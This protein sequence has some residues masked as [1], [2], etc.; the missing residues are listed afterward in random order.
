M[1]QE[2]RIL[3]NLK[4]RGTF[5]SEV[6]GAAHHQQIYSAFSGN[7]ATFAKAKGKIGEKDRKDS[8]K[9]GVHGY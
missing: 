3:K 1:S 9:R 6:F 2:E 7:D 4:L 8:K 5:I